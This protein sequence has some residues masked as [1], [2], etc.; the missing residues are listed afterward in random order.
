MEGWIMAECRMPNEFYEI[1]KPYLPVDRPVGPKGGRPRIS[2]RTVLKVLWY[3]LTTGCRWR[4]VPP[5]MGCSGETAR[6][7]LGEWESQGVWARLH[8]E[9]LRGLRRDG[10]L[11]HDTAVVDSVQVRAHGGGDRTGPS[12]VDRRKSGTKY[13]LLVD[14]H[15]APMA[16][17]IDPANRS[18]QTVIVPLVREQFPEVSGEPGRPRK[19]PDRVY[20]DAGYDSETTRNIM[21]CLGI[22][23]F[24]RKRNTEHGS[25]LGKV[26]W[27]VERTISWIKGLRRLRVRYD[28]SLPII[29]AWGSLAMAIINFRIWHYDINLQT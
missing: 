25:G 17:R 7:R 10:K 24:I 26:R 19:K 4:D 18:D 6:T 13:T 23:P 16:I 11:E 28:R 8:F 3:V 15:G 14:G 29:E 1:V 21:R 9:M 12:P 22:D 20:A 5:E 27:V 2:C